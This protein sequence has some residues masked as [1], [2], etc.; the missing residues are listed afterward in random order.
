MNKVLSSAVWAE[1]LD[2]TRK[3]K[4]KRGGLCTVQAPQ[5]SSQAMPAQA[6][7]ETPVAGPSRSHRA[8]AT[9]WDSLGAHSCPAGPC[10]S[11]GSWGLA[12]PTAGFYGCLG[13][14]WFSC[15]SPCRD[16]IR[17]FSGSRRQTCNLR[18]TDML[19][20]PQLESLQHFR[21]GNVPGFVMTLRKKER[22]R[23]ERKKSVRCTKPHSTN[24]C[25]SFKLFERRCT[26]RSGNPVEEG[27]IKERMQLNCPLFC[28]TVG[29]QI[30]RQWQKCKADVH[31]VSMW[32]S[33]SMWVHPR[34]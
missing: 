12:A 11:L 4:N 25:F 15:S 17:G 14:G 34:W 32:V 10:R 18:I 13:S 22:K 19:L 1:G 30:I 8:P 23:K 33:R 31:Y 26:A 2:C 5:D 28:K 24:Q 6:A 21:S 7:L 29:I 9:C 27:E 3:K 20:L 16:G